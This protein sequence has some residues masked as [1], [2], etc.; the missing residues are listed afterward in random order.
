VNFTLLPLIQ[1]REPA[2]SNLVYAANRAF[3]STFV[4]LYRVG[5]TDVSKGLPA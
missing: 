1:S 4:L 2:S 3:K 5:K